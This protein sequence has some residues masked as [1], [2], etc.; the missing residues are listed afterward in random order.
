MSLPDGV[1]DHLCEAVSRP[2]LPGTRYEVGALIGRGGMGA[3]YC[4]RD[5]QLDREVAIK[6][7]DDPV[8]KL[9]PLLAEAQMLA[10]LEHPGI[11]AVY[12]AGV[13]PDG[14]SF[15][16]MRRI[17]GMRLDAYL[18]ETRQSA[19]LAERLSIFGKLCDAVGFAHS[20]EVI[21]R[22]LKPENIMIGGFGE[23]IVLDWGVALW[24][25]GGERGAGTVAGTSRYMAPEQRCGGELD[26]RS[27]I[28]ALG[29]ILQELLPPTSMRRIS[30][31]GVS[32]R[33]L[34]AV[35]AKACEE[36][37]TSRYGCVADMALDVRQFQDHLPVS[38]YN[39]RLAERAVRFATRNRILLLLVASYVLVRVLL[40][41][42]SRV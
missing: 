14:R 16:V 39:E 13:L 40:F 17:E 31:H 24:T 1:L 10:R 6:V 20:R 7:I 37:R 29:M 36:D 5:T 28:Y 25:A 35:V 41:F 34:E 32:M 11:V 27:D 38:A 15:C 30:L 4:A 42:I 23:V 21:H 22:D 2:D 18:S 26:C 12:D 33:P 9:D 19:P 8:S 3:V